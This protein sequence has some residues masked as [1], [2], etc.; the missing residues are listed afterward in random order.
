MTDCIVP[1]QS[2]AKTFL[3]YNFWFEKWIYAENIT[4]KICSPYL[5]VLTKIFLGQ[6]VHEDSSY[7]QRRQHTF[8]Q[9]STYNLMLLNNVK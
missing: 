8:V 5:I 9:S 2:G 4:D 1:L 7:I 6:Q 3:E